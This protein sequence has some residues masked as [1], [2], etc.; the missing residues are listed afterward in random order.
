[1]EWQDIAY[2]ELKFELHYEDGIK[3]YG[4]PLQICLSS[5]LYQGQVSTRLGHFG[6]SYECW[7]GAKL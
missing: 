3:E 1:M 6:V 7:N 4:H 5:Q 2:I